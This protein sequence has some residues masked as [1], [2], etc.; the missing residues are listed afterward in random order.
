[1][2]LVAETLKVLDELLDRLVT[3][4]EVGQAE[5]Q[6]APLALRLGHPEPQAQLLNQGLQVLVLFNQ[7]ERYW[8]IVGYVRLIF[9]YHGLGSTNYLG[10]Y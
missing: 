4:G 8:I 6:V 7:A 1:M 10:L 9:E 2:K 5:G 3:V